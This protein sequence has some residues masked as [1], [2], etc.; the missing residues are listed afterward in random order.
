MI[1]NERITLSRDCPTVEIPSGTAKVLPSGTSVRLINSR[2]GSYTVASDM[3]ALYRVDGKDA[4][5]IGQTP[6]AGPEG[7]ASAGP[8]TEKTVAAQLRTVFDPEIPVNILDLGLVYACKITPLGN[9]PGATNRIDVKMTMTAPGCGM[10]NVLKDDVEKK[11]AS[12]PGVSE[13]NIEIVFDPPWNQSFMSEAARLQLG[14]DFGGAP[15][16]PSLPIFQPPRS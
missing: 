15:S 14:L 7:P 6:A 16:S 10:A 8:L 4:D 9:A 5:A 12:L 13:V 1:P 2:G 3:G 11:L